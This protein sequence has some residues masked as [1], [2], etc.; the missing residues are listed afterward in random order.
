[1]QRK[2]WLIGAGA[3]VALVALL[4]WAFAPRPLEVEVARVERGAFEVTLDED[5]R[6]RVLDRYTVSAPLSGSL[7]RITLREGDRVQA[8]TALAQLTPVLAP[9]LDARTLAELRARSQAAQVNVQR[10]ATRT[11]AARVALER[12]RNELRRSE[13]LAAQGF[14]SETK[15]ETDRLGVEAALREVET[16]IEGERIAAHERQQA[17]AAL[18][19]IEPGSGGLAFVVRSP[20]DGQVL[21][22]HQASEGVV[23]LG[24]PL[25]ELGDTAQLEVVVELLTTDALQAMPGRTVRIERWGGP[26][27]LEGRVERVEPAAFTKISALGVEEQRVRVIVALTSPPAAWAALGDGFRVGV[28][29]VTVSEPDVLWVPVSAVFPRT[30]ADGGGDAVF[31]VEG[32]RAKLQPVQVGGRNGRQAWITDG[33]SAGQS[34]IVYPS[35]AVD[36]GVRVK[37]REV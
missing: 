36:D 26:G 1:M 28:R 5:G 29:I 22:L 17:R 32:G 8:G 16:A 20:V 33:L 30:L 37:P 34:V 14:V 7:A 3:T 4:A 11:G 6:T 19:A 24:A 27:T 18:G 35:A 25:L 9:M 23:A 12:A 31:L 15:V 13:Q 10:A 2:S 21:R